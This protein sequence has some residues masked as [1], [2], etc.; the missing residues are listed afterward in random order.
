VRTA[1]AAARRRDVL[2]MFVAAGVAT[3]QESIEAENE[4]SARG[5]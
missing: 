1:R 2:K 4:L 5:I 3:S